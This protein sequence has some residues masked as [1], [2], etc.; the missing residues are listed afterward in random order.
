MENI[1]IESDLLPTNENNFTIK[2]KDGIILKEIK[3]FLL[4]KYKD[5]FVSL[6]LFYDS[7]S[8]IINISKVE[9]KSDELYFKFINEI[10]ESE[11]GYL[12]DFEK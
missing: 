4:D 12:F 8:N 10:G 9:K 3:K 6:S 11:Y 5:S 7:T 2:T 1:K